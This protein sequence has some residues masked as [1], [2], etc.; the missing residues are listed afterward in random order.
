MRLTWSK[1]FPIR[2]HRLSPKSTSE[3]PLVA[4]AQTAMASILDCLNHDV[5][6]LITME[7][8]ELVQG[9]NTTLTDKVRTPSAF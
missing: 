3:Q 6:Q 2:P 9:T 4:R 7:L 8:R 5:L 1:R